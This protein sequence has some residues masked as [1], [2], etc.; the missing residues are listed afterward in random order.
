MEK[1]NPSRFLTVLGAG[2]T[3]AVLSLMMYAEVYP[4]SLVSADTKVKLSGTWDTPL[5]QGATVS[6]LFRAAYD[7]L[8]SVRI[9]VRTYD[10]INSNTVIFR[11]RELGSAP[12]IVENTYVTDRFTDGYRYPFG[13]PLI[14]GSSG[15]T[16]EFQIHAQSGTPQ[17]AVGF[18]SG[19]Y[20]VTFQYAFPKTSF[21]GSPAAILRFLEVK[22]AN[23]ITDGA[24]GM[25]LLVCLLPAI[26]LC[27]PMF[28]KNG[29]SR[30]GVGTLLFLSAIGLFIA[31]PAT[32]HPDMILGLFAMGVFFLLSRRLSSWQVFASGLCFLILMIV[33]I[34]LGN[35]YLTPRFGQ[36]IFLCL[37]LGGIQIIRE[38]TVHNR[39]S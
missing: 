3:G 17:N 18:R 30:Q 9:P 16:Y 13:F 20:P 32:L 15:K 4:T 21:L 12:W 25:V 19:M 14:E 38:T 39:R 22:G 10:R 35:S 34:Y 5:I 36:G 33:Q 2:I 8:G 23:L 28:A 1:S 37:V 29:L 26:S 24:F 31:I 27:L 7:N 11:L 6:G